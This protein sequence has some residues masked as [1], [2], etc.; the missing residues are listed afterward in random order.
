MWKFLVFLSLRFYVKS[1][2]GI[3]E[4][5]NL[6]FQQNIKALNFD[7]LRI[8][9][10]LKAVNYQIDKIQSPE[11]AKVAVLELLHSLKLISRKI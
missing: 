4:V 6:P 10:L 3:L 11:I 9:A 8:F 7:V 1:I 5:Q 2:L